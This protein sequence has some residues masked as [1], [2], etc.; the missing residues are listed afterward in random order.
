MLL[1]KYHIP[2]HMLNNVPFHLYILPQHITDSLSQPEVFAC[3]FPSSQRLHTALGIILVDTDTTTLTQRNKRCVA[4]FRRAID[5]SSE[6]DTGN[7]SSVKGAFCYGTYS[8]LYPRRIRHSWSRDLFCR[9][10]SS[11]CIKIIVEGDPFLWRS[12]RTPFQR[13]SRDMVFCGSL[14]H[15]RSVLVTFHSRL[16]SW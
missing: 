16:D 14:A 11:F 4:Q 9:P 6:E 10:C 13:K 15:L 2:F 5:R 3:L 12:D 7:R 1:E 8:H